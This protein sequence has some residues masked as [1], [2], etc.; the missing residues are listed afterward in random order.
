LP[1]DTDAFVKTCR[2][3][4]G[5]DIAGLMC[6]PGRRAPGAALRAHREIAPQRA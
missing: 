4:Y 3:S 5:L 6:I 2:E 1:E